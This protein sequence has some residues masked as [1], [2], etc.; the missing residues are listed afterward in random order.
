MGPEVKHGRPKRWGLQNPDTWI[1]FDGYRCIAVKGGRE[2]TLFSR[3][4][5]VLN[6]RFQGVTTAL[7]SLEGDSILYGELVALDSQGRPSFQMLQAS[8]SQ[9]LPIYFYVFDVLNQNVRANCEFAFFPA[10]ATVAVKR[11]LL[12]YSAIAPST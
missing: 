3:N 7:A 10:G 4:Q 5:K 1:K 8:P 9:S 11:R 6:K 2:I 12:K